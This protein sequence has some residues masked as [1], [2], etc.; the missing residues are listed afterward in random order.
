M[1]IKISIKSNIGNKS[2]KNYVLFCSKSFNII[3]IK[4]YID[5]KEF[6]YIND[7]LKNTDTKK[8]LCSFDLSS[9]KKIILVNVKDDLSSSDVEKLGAEFY[10]FIKNFKLNDLAI[11]AKSIKEKPGRNFIGR[12]LHGFSLKSYDFTKYKSKKENRQI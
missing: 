12:F 7:L 8:N 5:N 4:K 6:N 2:A 1:S 11:N 9:K 10:D 3:N